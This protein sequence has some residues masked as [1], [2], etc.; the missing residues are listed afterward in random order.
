MLFRALDHLIRQNTV[1]V[2]SKGKESVSKLRKKVEKLMDRDIEQSIFSSHLQ[3]LKAA[4]L[5]ISERE[6]RMIFYSID[7]E[8]IDRAIKL[9]NQIVGI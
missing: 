4:E 6:G 5:I 8:K 2:L 3:T 9:S 1:L 7:A